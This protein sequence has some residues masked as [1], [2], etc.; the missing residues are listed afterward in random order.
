MVGVPDGTD[1]YG[2]GRL[3]ARD[4]DPSVRF[5]LRSDYYSGVVSELRSADL[6]IG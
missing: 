2:D 3:I 5:R 6:K 4:P 1:V